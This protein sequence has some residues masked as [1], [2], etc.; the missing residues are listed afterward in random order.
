MAESVGSVSVD[1]VPSAA[2]FGKKMAAQVEPQAK[3]L[4]ERIGRQLAD[5]IADSIKKGLGE[6]F[7]GTE[8]AS[9]KAGDRSGKSFGGEFARTARSRIEAALRSLPDA[10][11]G[12]ATSKADQEL[13]DLRA[14]LAA[15]SDKTIGVDIDEGQALAQIAEIQA[16]LTVLGSE[17]SSIEVKVNT[18]RAV[19]GTGRLPCRHRPARRRGR[20][21]GR[22]GTDQEPCF[23]RRGRH[24][25]TGGRDRSRGDWGGDRRPDPRDPWRR[26]RRCRRRA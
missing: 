15:L 26:S 19:G 9:K 16:A 24:V 22:S 3:S 17:S 5:K 14:R 20:R 7:V 6:G 10:Q 4:G 11:I 23:R 18:G 21:R 12:V 2:G 1:V 25:R 8:Q 13:K